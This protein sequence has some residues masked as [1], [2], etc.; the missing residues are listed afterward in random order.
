MTASY[1][2]DPSEFLHEH[3]EQA[4]PDLLRQ[5]MEGF[6]N[7]LLSAEAD[8]V[9]SA[10]HDDAFLARPSIPENIRICD[11]CLAA[12]GRGQGEVAMAATSGCPAQQDGPSKERG[13]TRVAE[14]GT[15]RRPHARPE[16]ALPTAK[17]AALTQYRN[18]SPIT[19]QQRAS[20]RPTSCIN[21]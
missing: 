15:G 19:V 12:S 17:P 9:C 10:A 21:L 3:L 2:N 16:A 13:C 8:R 18:S 1:S 20:Q 7:T 5:L 4:S 11:G 6:L 14:G